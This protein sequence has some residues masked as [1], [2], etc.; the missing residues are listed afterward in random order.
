MNRFFKTLLILSVLGLV[1]GAGYAEI[2]LEAFAQSSLPQ[3]DLTSPTEIAGYAEGL[4]AGGGDLSTLVVQITNY[5]LGFLGLAAIT[6]IIYAGILYV[7]NYG[8]DDMTGRAKSI[9]TYVVIGVMV[10]ILSYAIVNFLVAVV[11]GN[12]AGGG[13]VG[14]GRIGVGDRPVEEVSSLFDVEGKDYVFP[15]A[16]SLNDLGDVCPN[17]PIGLLVNNFGCASS[18]LVPDT[19]FDG[20]S[21][22]LDTDD[23]GDGV[24]DQEDVDDDGDGICD[25]GLPKTSSETGQ[26]PCTSGPD[27][28]PDTLSFIAF[29]S[30]DIERFK[31]QVD[32][33]SEQEY[34]DY[35]RENMGCAEYQKRSDIDGDGVIDS[36]DCDQD[37]DGIL[38]TEECARAYFAAYPPGNTRSADLTPS[39][40]TDDG[41][42]I[43]DVIRDDIDQ[44]DDND[45]VIDFG[46]RTDLGGKELLLRSVSNNFNA[47]ERFIRS[48]CATLPQSQQVVEY[49]GYN[50]DGRPFGKL[51]RILDELGSDLNFVDFETFNRLYQEFLGIAGAFPQVRAVLKADRFEGP[52]PADGSGFQVNFDASDSEDFYSEFC[53]FSDDNYYWF[54]NKTLDFSQGINGLINSA[55]NAPDGRGVFFSNT[56]EEPGIYNVQ[57][58]VRS[59][60]KLN[61]VNPGAGETDDVDAAIAGLSTARIRVFPPRARL[62][63]EVDG[64]PD[65]GGKP[66]R[67]LSGTDTPLTFDLRKSV[68]N[69]APFQ[70][71]DYDCGNGTSARIQGTQTS[72]QFDCQYNNP[73]A[74]ETVLLVARDGAGDVQR[75][76]VLQ[77]SDVIAA[78]DVS[79]GTR[80]NGSTLF[81]FDASRSASNLDIT[82]YTYVVRRVTGSGL[83]EIT[84]EQQQQFS[85]TFPG[86]GEYE[87]S[88]EVSVPGLEPAVDTVRIV[89]DERTPIAAFEVSFPENIR[90]NRALLD[91][92]LSFHPDFNSS[93]ALNYQWEVDGVTLTPRG[94]G[95]TGIYTYDREVDGNDA[96]IFYSF[97]SVGDHLVVLTV[98]RGSETAQVSETVSVD[99]LLGADFIV[100]KP[101]AHI[102]EVI[103]FTPNSER[104]LGFFWDFKDGFTLV[105]E[106]EPVV[107]KFSKQGVYDVTLQ[108][109]D[110]AGNE[111][112]VTKKVR[113]GLANR[114]VA[115]TKVFVNSIEQDQAA[116][117]CIEVTRRDNVVFDASDSISVQGEKLGIDFLWKIEEFDEI[118][119]SRTFSRIFRDLDQGTCID[120]D[121]T[122]TDLSTN[123]TDDAD[124]ISIEV[125][126]SKPTLSAVNVSP[127]GQ[128]R[129]TPLNVTVTAAGVRD[130]DGR[131]VKYRWWYYEQGNPQKEID[132]RI[133]DSPRT[134]FVI[135]PNDVEG[136]ESTYYFVV[137]AE[138]NDGG[139]VNSEKLLGE[140]TP[141]VVVNGPNVAPIAE[142]VT[143]RSTVNIGETVNFTS[144]TKDPLGEFIPSAGYQW[145]FDGDGEFER[146]ASGSQ[147]TYQYEQPGVYT[148]KLRVT[149]NGLSS[150]YSM[151]VRV[152]PNT[153]DPEA[154]FVFVQSGV[155][156]KFINNSTVDPALDD[157]SLDYSWD[158]DTQIDSDGNGQPDDDTDSALPN[159]VYEFDGSKDYLVGLT[160]TDSVGNTDTVTRKIFFLK[161]DVR[162]PLGAT[163]QVRLKPILKTNPPRNTLDG[164][165]YLPPPSSDVIFNAQESTGKIQEYRLDTN[166]FVDSD[167]DGIPDN[168]VDNK[169]HPSWKDGSS[170]RARY[171]VEQGRIRAKLTV[172]SI[173]GALKS[174]V[175]D[176]IFSEDDPVVG[177]DIESLEDPDD[178][179]A[180]LNNTAQV[181]FDVSSPF[182]GPG[183]TI[184]FDASRT[185]FPD[186]QVEEYRWDFDGD[187]LVDEISFEPT[188]SHSYEQE[189]AYDVILEAVSD[190]GLQGEYIVTVFVR[191]G[192]QLPVAD[193]SYALS[194]NA[195][196]FTD[197]STF[198]SSFTEDELGYTWTFS[199]LDLAGTQ[200]EWR[201]WTIQQDYTLSDTD[202]GG[203]PLWVQDSLELGSL[204]N[205][206]GVPPVDIIL[207]SDKVL[208]K[209]AEGMPLVD[210][211]NLPAV[212]TL[213]LTV[214][215]NASVSVSDAE[216][217]AEL[218]TGFG[219]ELKTSESFEVIVDGVMT[220]AQ[221][222][223][224]LEDAESG[225]VSTVLL[226]DGTVDNNL[227]SFEVDRLPIRMLITGVLEETDATGAQELGV[228]TVREPVKVFPESGAYQVVLEV[229]DGVGETSSKSEVI[230]IDENLV[231]REPGQNVESEEVDAG[232][233]DV[234]GEGDDNVV[235]SPEINMDV[236]NGGFSY[237]WLVLVVFIVVAVGAVVFIV[238]RTI[239]QRQQEIESQGGVPAAA[240]QNKN[241]GGSKEKVVEE[242]VEPEVVEKKDI[243]DSKD[244]QDA[245]DSNMDKGKV[246][247]KSSSTE[248]AAKPSQKEK[249]KK[250]KND[251]GKKP[252]KGPIPDWLKN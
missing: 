30:T 206:S 50:S 167:G 84:R 78:L 90:P 85:Y 38:D 34:N 44:D 58:L 73:N 135:G 137:E 225:E 24:V 229:E 20:V 68:T 171:V 211:D 222:Y 120:V 89:I 147:V 125:V 66:V 248:T 218:Q 212:G 239:Q 109:Q 8:N 42:V 237:F 71:L 144:T 61:T 11:G 197:L 126:N 133:T 235:P 199:R 124:T 145:D 194:E 214:D 187:G 139:S 146:N 191:G 236:D 28:C 114:P 65:P 27:Q 77:F 183:E 5:V 119:R 192:L 2:L 149:K 220:G 179:L 67:I 136:T 160:I 3:Y 9:L 172:V 202:L 148:P 74:T 198:D 184:T 18:E 72:W 102:N 56:F 207:G 188:I 221:L 107:H 185:T 54:V 162:G 140:S 10:I 223:E 21:N 83:E 37:A 48:T 82:N 164:R 242:V 181:S 29:K 62:V 80:G 209:L 224:V 142:F 201:D 57:L 178:I 121:L 238:V 158:F 210:A 226:S 165:L 154:A 94:P 174:E 104:A 134:T 7:A 26:A 151:T 228:S 159:P 23:D 88:L 112:S 208:L 4:Q 86:P 153:E 46:V 173:D 213:A 215:E 22:L 155:R 177:T 40:R 98:S 141:L 170:Y 60:C 129:V 127:V 53:P 55:S 117:G 241:K 116:S 105:A 115:L 186:E 157:K 51:V 156:V 106:N 196:Q 132:L 128:E 233:G 169:T 195:V 96:R 92:T 180:F 25:G 168:D 143:N 45:G 110:A 234:S 101:A 31:I 250:E 182:V 243:K 152:L 70:Y 166:I 32:R 100:D 193:F 205:P 15:L 52:L 176:I 246:E 64:Q 6:A 19:D 63:V 150:D 108:V 244:T 161:R 118:E 123:T 76:V 247:K 97:Q 41:V 251:D 95:N 204:L 175:I 49:C 252:P 216:T 13:G 16:S 99:S 230:T 130:L 138:D 217:F 36:E 113:I 91:A 131:I 59:A 69:Q 240:P 190:G 47:L 1:V 12:G 75:P 200:K 93:S 17:T 35:I 39:D 81:T 231:L 227:T 79:P 103:T 163:K 189:G 219:T 122:V 232:Q 87:V 14:T 33:V 249:P 245:K 203:A 111:N 43:L